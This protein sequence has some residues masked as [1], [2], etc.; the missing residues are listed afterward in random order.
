MA[1]SYYETLGVPRDASEKDI[2]SSYR[3]LA[4][5]YHPD[6]NRGDKG[7]ES[8]FKEINE[9]YQVLA[10]AEDRKKYDRFGDDWR[11]ADRLTRAGGAGS[12]PSTWFGRGRRRGGTQ[13]PGAG[14]SGGAGGF[15]DLFGDLFRTRPS[16]GFE[17][18]AP[19]Q[20][21]DVPITMTLEEAY[22]GAKR[23]VQTAPD[24]FSGEAG[25][26][27]EVTIPAGVASGARVHV[28]APGR[29][30]APLDLYLSITVAPHARFERKG[31][32]LLLQV[33]VPL[34]DAVLGG[35]VEVSTITGVKVAL[36][37]PPET[38]N[39]RVFR[40]RGKGMPKGRGGGHGDLL[41]TVKVVLPVDLSDEHREL[42]KQLR[43]VQGAAPDPQE[44]PTHR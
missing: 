35:E 20:Q 30:G 10:D 21:V 13:A 6:V 15:G 22:A 25:R 38:Q 31:N 36:K 43:K 8:R 26:R 32:D 29:G 28:G 11:H 24:P 2:R 39:G 12:S 44:G 40:L 4:R 1:K 9:A 17:G 33:S 19:R 42:F 23:M 41:A 27:I 3:R 34:V 5:R 37:L 18:F 16:A 7:A 14:S